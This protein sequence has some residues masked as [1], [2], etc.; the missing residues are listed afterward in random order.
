[1]SLVTT[2]KHLGKLRAQLAREVIAMIHTQCAA[3]STTEECEQSHI[4]FL[5]WVLVWFLLVFFLFEEALGKLVKE[6]WNCLADGTYVAAHSLHVLGDKFERAFR[7]RNVYLGGCIAICN[8]G[9]QVHIEF[10]EDSLFIF[11]E[12]E[13]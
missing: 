13:W 1:M 7:L 5:K 6:V 12:G 10:L 3:N 4:L 9:Q 11:V 2:T 8:F